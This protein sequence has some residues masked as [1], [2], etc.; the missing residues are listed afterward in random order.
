MTPAVPSVALQNKASRDPIRI[1]QTV[2]N[3]RF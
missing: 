1:Q 3:V 2:A